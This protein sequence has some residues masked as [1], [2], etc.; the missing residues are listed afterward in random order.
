ML[1]PILFWKRSR[2][3]FGTDP[4]VLSVSIRAGFQND[5]GFIIDTGFMLAL[6]S[7]FFENWPRFDFTN[8]PRFISVFIPG[9]VLEMIVVLF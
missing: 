7:S 4:S 2:Y 1:I 6:N 5:P 9:F 3:K 8:D